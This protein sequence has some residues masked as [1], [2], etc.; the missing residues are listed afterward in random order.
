M[1]L[2]LELKLNLILRLLPTS[3]L[4]YYFTNKIDVKAMGTANKRIQK[5][6]DSILAA[7]PSGEANGKT[8]PEVAK[9]TDFSVATI[10]NDLNWLRGQKLVG[11]DDSRT[12]FKWYR[13]NKAK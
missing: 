1:K 11:C 12:P 10:R 13:T 8:Y 5:R 6:R 9:G 2:Q 3:N 4:I 7:L